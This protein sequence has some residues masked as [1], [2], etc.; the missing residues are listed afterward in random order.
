MNT[1][2]RAELPVKLASLLAI[3]LA[4]LLE[5][6]GRRVWTPKQMRLKEGEK[7]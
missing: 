3:S 7:K 5:R 1:H 4:R 6:R 2:P